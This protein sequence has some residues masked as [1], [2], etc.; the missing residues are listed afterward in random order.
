MDYGLVNGT[1]FNKKEI[2][3]VFFFLPYLLIYL[4]HRITI[5]PIVFK[6]V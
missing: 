3:F 4:G 5:I 6:Y 2:T 1:D